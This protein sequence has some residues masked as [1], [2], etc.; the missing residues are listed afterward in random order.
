MEVITVSDTIHKLVFKNG[1]IITLVGT[2]HVSHNSVEEVCAVLDE[3]KPDRICLELDKGRF[4][5]KTNRDVYANMNLRKIFKEGKA[6]LLLANTALASFQKRL[7]TKLDSAPGDELMSAGRIALERDI[8]FSFCDRDIS[9][10]F[11]RS[12]RKSSF[13]QKI[14]LLAT[15]L[16]AAFSKEEIT[17]E[18]LERLKTSDT[19]NEMLSSMAQELP[20]VKK[21][22]IDERDEYLAK[23]IYKAEGHNKVAIIGA[24]HTSGIIDF[25]GKCEECSYTEAQLNEQINELSFVPDNT[26]GK[27]IISWSVPAVLIGFIVF[28]CLTYGFK[29][30]MMTFFTWAVAD[31][32]GAMFMAIISLGHPLTWIVAAITAPI[33]VMSPVLGVGMFSGIM[34]SEVRK[35]TVEDFEKLV[36]DVSSFRKWFSNKVLHPLLLFITTSLGSMIG[37][38]VLFPIFRGII[39]H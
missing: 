16:S 30:G 6:F 28:S 8:P 37:T 5:S 27:K 19:L 34:E 20:N 35:P 33:S 14:K 2:A 26:L 3:V 22:L 24:G 15:L 38:L 31:A 36:D 12:W 17:Q 10:T 29:G 18:E 23:S 21:V 1:D 13:W 25:L 39:V 32:M 11:K 7:G 9:V 4:E